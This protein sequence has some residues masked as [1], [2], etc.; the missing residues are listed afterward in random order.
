MFLVLFLFFFCLTDKCFEYEMTADVD[1]ST[2]YAINERE[3]TTS[4]MFIYSCLFLFC[5]CFSICLQLLFCSNFYSRNFCVIHHKKHL[6]IYCVG[7]VYHCYCCNSL[8]FSFFSCCEVRWKYSPS[9]NSVN[10]RYGIPHARNF[11]IKSHIFSG[12]NSKLIKSHS[13]RMHTSFV[14]YKRCLFR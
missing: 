10:L 2:M 9:P 13:Y 7:H 4:S 6:F 14:W 5:F 1:G 11:G 3:Y 12:S 8:W